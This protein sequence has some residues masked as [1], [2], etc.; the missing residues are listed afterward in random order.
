MFGEEAQ[1]LSPKGKNIFKEY[2][3]WYTTPDGVYI[4]I[5]GTT[6]APNWIPNLVLETLLLEEI[7]CQTYV[8]G[9]A[10]SLHRNKKGLCLLF[11]LSTKFF[12]IENFKQAKDEVGIVTSFKFR[13]VSFRRHDLEGKMKQSMQQVGFI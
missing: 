4:K 3:D 13:E 9:V 2:G 1:C 11:P 7:D 8:N 12:K 5:L 10:S 6:K